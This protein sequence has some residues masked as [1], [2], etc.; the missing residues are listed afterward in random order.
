LLLLVL[1]L[2]SG[3]ARA[4]SPLSVEIYGT[5]KYE[6]PQTYY[7]VACNINL[8]N[9]SN[10]TVQITTNDI[11]LTDIDGNTYQSVFYSGGYGTYY[12]VYG[13]P[14]LF[15]YPISSFINI[16]PEA[17]VNLR[18]LFYLP[19]DKSPGYVIIKYKNQEITRAPVFN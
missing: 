14:I 15:S 8:Q 2:T 17:T 19:L 18:A 4:L 5:T 3:P 9:R 12:D 10:Q 13:R 11:V 16:L 7:I 6:I 1:S